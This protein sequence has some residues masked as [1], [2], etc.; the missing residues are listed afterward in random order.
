MQDAGIVDL[1]PMDLGLLLM[2]EI[3]KGPILLGEAEEA[4]PV[5]G[6]HPDG[7]SPSA[8]VARDAKVPRGDKQG[9]D[10]GDLDPGVVHRP[11][12]KTGVARKLGRSARRGMGVPDR[13]I[14]DRGKQ[15]GQGAD[16]AAGAEGLGDGVQA[17]GRE[18][19]AT[20]RSEV[21]GLAG[22]S[23]VLDPGLAGGLQD[24]VE[25]GDP[26]G[27]EEELGAPHPA[28]VARAEDGEQGLPGRGIH[29]EP[30]ASRSGTELGAWS[31]RTRPWVLGIPLTSCTRPRGR[32]APWRR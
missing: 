18:T 16:G 31:R 23:I 17:A 3:A 24:F 13:G 15:G 19:Q 4:F 25:M 26:S 12:H 32:A 28:R 8:L 30:W 7:V 5:L 22:D 27:L 10:G 2:E 29:S 6:S 11:D 9:L 20:E 1:Q 21:G 14:P